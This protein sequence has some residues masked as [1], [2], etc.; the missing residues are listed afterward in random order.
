MT[1]I[2][3]VS[4]ARIEVFVSE[5]FDSPAWIPIELY[6]SITQHMKDASD[7]IILLHIDFKEENRHKLMSRCNQLLDALAA[8]KT[9][10]TEPTKQSVAL[11]MLGN[12]VRTIKSQHRKPVLPHGGR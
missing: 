11:I 5:H 2:S 3:M 6:G 9:H 10:A 4:R 7:E 8:L 1:A 12:M